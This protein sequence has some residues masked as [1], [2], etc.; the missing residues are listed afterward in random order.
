MQ[1]EVCCGNV[2][3]TVRI[4]EAQSAP[5]IGASVGSN[6]LREE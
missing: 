5:A 6:A 1:V 4:A 3:A 2:S